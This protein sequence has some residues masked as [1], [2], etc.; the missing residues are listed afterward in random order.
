MKPMRAHLLFY[1]RRGSRQSRVLIDWLRLRT[2]EG[3]HKWMTQR[4]KN[5]HRLK[6]YNNTVA[7]VG[8]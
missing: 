8:V 5:D 6:S 4:G 7:A 2:G 3:R 1:K